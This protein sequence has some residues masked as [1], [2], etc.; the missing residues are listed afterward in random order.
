M[1]AGLRVQTG[2]H[3][4]TPGSDYTNSGPILQEFAVTNTFP[5]LVPFIKLK[6]GKQC[7]TTEE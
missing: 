4:L 5:A 3:H 7:D 2:T 6:E 1:E